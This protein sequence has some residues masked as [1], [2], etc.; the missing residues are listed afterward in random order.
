MR[1]F[2]ITGFGLDKRAFAPLQL[3][4]EPYRLVDLIPVNKGETLREYALRLSK[5]IGLTSEDMVGGVSLG[6]ML[7]LE[8]DKAMGTRGVLIIASAAHPRF[9]RQKFLKLAYITPWMPEF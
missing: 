2:L 5:D 6:G 3:P 8:M 9:I 4:A 1:V 7:A